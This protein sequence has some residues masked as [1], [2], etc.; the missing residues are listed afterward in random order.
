VSELKFDDS[1]GAKLTEF[2]Y[3]IN[4][5]DY[6]FQFCFSILSTVGQKYSSTILVVLIDRYLPPILSVLKPMSF[7]Y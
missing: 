1:N 6:K 7:Q 3:E 5:Q 4:M 2:M